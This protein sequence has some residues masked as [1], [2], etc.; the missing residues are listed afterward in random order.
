[1][2]KHK[3]NCNNNSRGY[4]MSQSSTFG[5]LSNYSC[6]HLRSLLYMWHYMP[7]YKN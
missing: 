2:M 4:C 6:F 1:M 5:I 7:N 3:Q